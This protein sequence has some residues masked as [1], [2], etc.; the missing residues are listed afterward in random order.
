MVEK[1]TGGFSGL[2]SAQLST[3]PIA[4]LKSEPSIWTGGRDAHER[5]ET[6]G[7]DKHEILARRVHLS[8]KKK[9]RDMGMCMYVGAKTSGLW[10]RRVV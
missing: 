7:G 6:Q 2:R 8:N 3:A 5:E 9:G 1:S 10:L 4:V